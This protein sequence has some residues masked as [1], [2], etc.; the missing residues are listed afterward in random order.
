MARG[1]HAARSNVRRADAMAE[2]ID[3]LTDQLA[4]AKRRV[5]VA[6]EQVR[7]AA[8]LRER[9][10]YLEHQIESDAMLA[11]FLKA[12]DPLANKMRD[13]HEWLTDLRQGFFAAVRDVM[14]LAGEMNPTG[15][16]ILGYADINEFASKR[17]P[18][19][20]RHMGTGAQRGAHVD[21]VEDRTLLRLTDDEIRRLQRVRGDRGCFAFRPD[22]TVADV[23]VDILD[24]LDA[25]LD[26]TELR[27]YIGLSNSAWCDRT[28]RRSVRDAGLPKDEAQELSSGDITH[29][30]GVMK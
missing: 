12:F 23:L 24:A 15:T 16:T 3:R 29:L 2:H 30:A 28:V 26:M 25:D 18:T 27:E 14:V 9:V 13:Q 21:H 6:E 7:K 5:V 4:E 1:K 10:K 17:Y 22:S 20:G 8:L 11:K 19:V